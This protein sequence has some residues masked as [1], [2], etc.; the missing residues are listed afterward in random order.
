MV[1]AI[2]F[3]LLIVA[4]YGAVT[5]ALNYK[6]Q[7]KIRQADNVRDAVELRKKL[8]AKRE[9]VLVIFFIIMSVILLVL[10]AADTRLTFTN[11]VVV[12]ALFVILKYGKSKFDLIGNVSYFTPED[13]LENNN[14]FYLYL[15]GFE[16]DIPFEKRDEANETDFQEAEFTN[17]VRYSLDIPVCALGMSKEV[18]S[19]IGAIRVYVEDE[20]WKEKVIELMKMAEKIFILINNRKSCIWEIEQTQS[21]LDKT[22]FI[23]D[24][25]K[26]YSV[27]R[28]LFSNEI[29]M[30]ETP[31][32]MQTP[33]F[34]ESGMQ[35]VLFENNSEGYLTILGIDADD[36]EEKKIA[37]RKEQMLADSKKD[38]VK[39]VVI[40][41]AI[42]VFSAIWWGLT[43]LVMKLIYDVIM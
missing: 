35:A 9:N 2:L 38:A 4:V 31:A 30:P 6:L 12:V 8:I 14:R 11:Y 41:L 28:N 39:A 17:A 29:I 26:D 43:F 21:W 40:L 15:R 5:K 24:D 34:F 7:E 18:D 22:V 23:V 16:D 42:V 1:R 25:L 37:E 32:D 27:I 3:A 10:G 33:F 19:P 20:N 13:F 36:L